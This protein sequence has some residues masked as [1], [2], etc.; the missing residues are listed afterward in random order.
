MYKVIIIF[1][2]AFCFLQTANG[3]NHLLLKKEKVYPFSSNN[4]KSSFEFKS[5]SVEERKAL[6]Q[7]I[8]LELID[9]LHLLAD[10]YLK[11]AEEGRGEKDI[12]FSDPVFI[13]GL[14]GIMKKNI[15]SLLFSKLPHFYQKQLKIQYEEVEKLVKAGG[16]T[17]SPLIVEKLFNNSYGTDNLEYL[18]ELRAYGFENNDDLFDRFSNFNLS[19]AKEAA[20]IALSKLSVKENVTYQYAQVLLEGARIIEKATRE[21]EYSPSEQAFAWLSE[22]AAQGN[23]E[24]QYCLGICYLHGW[25]IFKDLQKSK[26]WLKKSSDQGNERARKELEQFPEH[27][28]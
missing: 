24:A 20:T 17:P 25:G 27:G 16:L 5:F 10:F 9:K 28:K 2:V 11:Q 7:Y 13:N 8:N 4:K 26:E 23:A 12:D 22:K 1:C 18:K 15:D 3:E 14:K 21:N 6:Y 19:V